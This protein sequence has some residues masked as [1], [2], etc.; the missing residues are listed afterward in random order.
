MYNSS[1]SPGSWPG[2]AALYEA[3]YN[4]AKQKICQYSTAASMASWVVLW[5]AACEKGRHFWTGT[6]GETFGGPVLRIPHPPCNLPSSFSVL[7]GWNS[8][9]IQFWDREGACEPQKKLS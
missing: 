5:Y 4:K 6:V 3:V 7:G 9:L 8:L 1:P 2:W